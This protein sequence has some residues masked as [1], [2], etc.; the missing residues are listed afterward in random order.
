V[1]I[2]AIAHAI[3]RRYPAAWRERYEAEVRGLIDDASIQFRDLGE[4]LRGLFAERAREFLTSV[5]NPRRTATIVGFMAP[6][7]G[8]VFLI[9]A[10][11]TGYA[12]KSVVGPLSD[13]E[14]YVGL[15]LAVVLMIVFF[16]TWSRGWKRRDGS[17]AATPRSLPPDVVVVMLPMLFVQVA[18]FAV[19]LSGE[20]ESPSLIP[21]WLNR[22]FQ[23]FV[24]ASIA[25][26]LLSSLF[27]G[28]A[29]LQAFTNVSYA[30][31]QVLSNEKWV[32][33]CRE[34]ISKGVPSPLQ[35][36]LA[37][38][39]KWTAERDSA[40]ARLKELGYEARFRGVIGRRESGRETAT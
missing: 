23:L 30:E 16:V 2:R 27:P 21:N 24:W 25:G 13:A 10:W 18:L 37:Q 4:L 15:S 35:D 14:Q 33:G 5:D 28:H 38:V 7:A 40:R 17:A 20:P 3:V 19:I 31:G 8:G 22:V 9:V 29:L 12:M 36:A 34:M 11:L 1:T 32:E 6:V 39:G 26:N